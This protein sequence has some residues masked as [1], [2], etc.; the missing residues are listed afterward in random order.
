MSDL[1]QQLRKRKDQ[2][3]GTTQRSIHVKPSLLFDGREAARIETTAIHL[4]ALGGLEQLKKL[5]PR[6]KSFEA[7]LVIF[8]SHLS[9]IIDLLFARDSDHDRDLVLLINDGPRK[10][11]YLPLPYSSRVRATRS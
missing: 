10:Y 3:V 9:L 8:I 4:L 11:N 7:T 5:E 2:T 6:L 1:A